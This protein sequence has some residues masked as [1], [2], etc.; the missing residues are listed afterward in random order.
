MS[1]RTV[2][3]EIRIKLADGKHPFVP[4]VITANGRVKPFMGLVN[5]KEEQHKEG[6]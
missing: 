4:A 2:T 3:L 5:G 1:G 6:R